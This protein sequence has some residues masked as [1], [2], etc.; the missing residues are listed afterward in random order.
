LPRE[1]SEKDRGA[2]VGKAPDA[3]ADKAVDLLFAS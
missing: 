1:E 2:L 3:I